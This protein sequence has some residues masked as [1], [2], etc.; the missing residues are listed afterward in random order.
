MLAASETAL[1]AEL[2]AVEIHS[3]PEGATND[4]QAVEDWQH[5]VPPPGPLY[6]RVVLRPSV[7][8]HA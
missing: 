7:A 6:A 5:L 4:G 2:P 8:S 3:S 1:A